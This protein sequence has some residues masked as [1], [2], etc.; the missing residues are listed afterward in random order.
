MCDAWL[1]ISRFLWF[2]AWAI[3]VLMCLGFVRPQVKIS[4]TT[5]GFMV[6]VIVCCG[7]VIFALW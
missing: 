3:L 4:D 6:F 1:I 5:A 2:M 7:A